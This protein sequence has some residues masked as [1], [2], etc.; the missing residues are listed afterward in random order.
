M[1]DMPC[2]IIIPTLRGFVARTAADTCREYI[3]HLIGSVHYSE[4]VGFAN[5]AL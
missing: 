1:A 4:V 3:A 5:M 2:N